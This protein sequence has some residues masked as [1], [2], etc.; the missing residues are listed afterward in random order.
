[1]GSVGYIRAMQHFDPLV[2]STAGLMEPVIATLIVFALGI[3]AL[4][5]WMGWIGNVLVAGGTLAVIYPSSGQ[6]KKDAGH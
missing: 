3:G 4:P 1:M 5:G 2:V 6:E